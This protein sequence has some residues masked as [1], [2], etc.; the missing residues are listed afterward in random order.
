M[1]NFPDFSIHG[2]RVK[3]KLGSNAA[4]GRVTYLAIDLDTFEKVVIKQFQFAKSGSSWAGYDSY[5]REIQILK[6]LK[7]PGICQYLSSFQTSDGFCMVQ[8]YKPALSLAVSCGF[9]TD[10]TQKIATTVL[11]ILIY[12]Q[13]Q[14]P[15]IIHRDIKPENILIDELSNIYLIDFGFARAGNGEV[16][17]SSVVKGTLGFMPPEQLFNRQLTESSDLYG[18]GMTLICIL[19]GTSSTEI[20]NLI[21]STYRIDFSHLLPQ[22]NVR[23]LKWLQKMVE[24]SVK[25]RYPNAISAL[26]EM[27]EEPIY[28]PEAR[29]NRSSLELKSTYKREIL[30]QTITVENSIC[31]TLLQGIWEVALHPNDPRSLNHE[32][33]WIVIQP[34]VFKGNHVQCQ[35][36]IDTGRLMTGKTYQRELLLHNNSSTS[37]Q[38]LMLQVQTPSTQIRVKKLPYRFLALLFLISCVIT[39]T[40]IQSLLVAGFEPTGAVSF[41]MITGTSLGLEGT[42]WFMAM[43]GA[44][45]GATA[46]VVAGVAVGLIALF[47]VVTDSLSG[48]VNVS[49]VIVTAGLM[50]GVIAGVLIGMVTETLYE[51]GFRKENS[52]A[53]AVLTIA[54]AGVIGVG[55]TIGFSQPSTIAITIVTNMLLLIALARPLMERMKLVRAYQDSERHLIQP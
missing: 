49:G 41:G 30:T 37:P 12:L 50:S 23:W 8:E 3:R 29:L 45:T 51:Q 15:S 36:T 5:R 46:G 16:A 13:K 42:A 43:I 40:L 55:L 6:S 54:A 28:L 17:I 20:G 21:D 34:T 33:T 39:C 4:G 38:S 7:H 27:P 35:I 22:V 26:T 19:T 18:L 31:E 9:S 1:S 53:L 24:P 32:H 52:I 10:E 44:M 14:T 48:S 25:D 47:M 11:E 2:Y